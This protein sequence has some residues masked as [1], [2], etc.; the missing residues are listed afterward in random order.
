MVASTI[1]K[2]SDQLLDNPKPTHKRAEDPD[3]ADNA[4]GGPVTIPEITINR[5]TLA[6]RERRRIQHLQATALLILAAATVLVLVY[7]AKLLLVVIL[8]SILLSFV[9][10][11]IVDLLTRFNIPRALGALLSVSLLVVALGAA[12]YLSY[13][14]ALSI[15]AR[16]AQ[17]QSPNPGDGS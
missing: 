14:R 3:I 10:A 1:S 6:E 17:V 2:M 13:S 7:V 4:A 16:G 9:L 5:S 8:L 12:S 11:P 15:H